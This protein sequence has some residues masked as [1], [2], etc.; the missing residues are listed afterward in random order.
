[1]SKTILAKAADI[2]GLKDDGVHA[3]PA[4]ITDAKMIDIGRIIAG[5]SFG[6]L[7]LTDGKPR[8][9]TTKCLVRT[10]LL[11]LSKSAWKKCEDDIKK[12][13]TYDRV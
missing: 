8:I 4:E 10:H 9:T 1:M 3:D 2:H 6:A 7:A 12:R 5:G 13:K 11:V